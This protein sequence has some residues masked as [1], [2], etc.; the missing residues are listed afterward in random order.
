VSRAF[1]PRRLIDPSVRPFTIL[2]CAIA[3]L[4]A[5]DQGGGRFLSLATAFSVMQLFATL[6]P[7]AL[8]LGLSMLIK[9]FDLSVAGM[10]SL[11]GCVAVLTGAAN[12]WLGALL[13]VGVG[14]VGGTLQGLIMTRLQIPSV[15][16]TLG[17]LLTFE[18]ITYVLTRSQTIVYPNMG[19]ALA[20]NQPILSV[21]SMRSAI[22]VGVFLIA[23]FVMSLTRIGRD[24]IATGSDRRASRIAGV[25]TEA[26]VV[27]VFA[28]S[29]ALSALSGVMLSYSLA[30]AS[31]IALSDVLVPAAAAAI[32]GGVS[33]TGG[34]GR[35]LSIGAGVL[36]L[37]LLRSGLNA[38][39]AS[40][41]LHEIA[42][43]AV[44]LAVAI[45]D[46]PLLARRMR[47]WRL[48]WSA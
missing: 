41:F 26:V 19:V 22:T 47:S 46:A 28:V 30:A 31:P 16:V 45:V 20:L 13:G 14:A 4:A 15:G 5:A 9:E 24:V 21:L 35:P 1:A 43:G 40:P 42:T 23:A 2:F 44:L 8:G 37:C 32:I 18:G 3:A 12:P 27:G 29:G 11:A 10:L 34:T 38:V 36:I 25:R 6:G 17:G 39:G 33:L 48:R 7:V